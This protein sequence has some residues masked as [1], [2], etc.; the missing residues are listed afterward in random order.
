MMMVQ[1]NKK[2][3]THTEENQ[4]QKKTHIAISW[5]AYTRYITQIKESDDYITGG[6]QQLTDLAREAYNKCHSN[7]FWEILQAYYTRNTN[8]QQLGRR[9]ITMGSLSAAHKIS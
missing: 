9:P 2:S 4:I 5:A 1:L 8:P 3:E 7:E 6:L